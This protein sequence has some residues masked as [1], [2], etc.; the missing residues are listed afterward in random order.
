MRVA[1]SF[2]LLRPESDNLSGDRR[3]TYRNNY[4][5]KHRLPMVP[6][7][8][9]FGPEQTDRSCCL[10]DALRRKGTGSLEPGAA[11]TLAQPQ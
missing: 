3:L 4:I 7:S 9:W 6:R 8:T 10:G 1:Q 2:L 11:R 5:L